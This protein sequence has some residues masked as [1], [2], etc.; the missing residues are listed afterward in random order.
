MSDK[1]VYEMK[2]ISIVLKTCC[3]S[4]TVASE[5]GKKIKGELGIP[6]VSQ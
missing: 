1:F 6:R 4:A 5:G 2:I 3:Q